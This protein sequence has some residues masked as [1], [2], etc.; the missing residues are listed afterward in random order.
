MIASPKQICME[1]VHQVALS[2]SAGDSSATNTSRSER[3]VTIGHQQRLFVEMRLFFFG[4]N[5]IQHFGRGLGRP[6]VANAAAM[7]RGICLKCLV[8]CTASLLMFWTKQWTHC[9]LYPAFGLS[10]GRT[11]NW[12][13]LLKIANWGLLFR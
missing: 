12:G 11:V 9:Q 7:V 5:L 2:H 1:L 13:M 3:H 8:R 6:C 10:S 4:K